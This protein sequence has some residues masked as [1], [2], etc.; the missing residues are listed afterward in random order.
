MNYMYFC[1]PFFVSVLF[2]QIQSQ[3]DEFSASENDLNFYG[4]GEFYLISN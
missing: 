2:T 3:G 1:V 4:H